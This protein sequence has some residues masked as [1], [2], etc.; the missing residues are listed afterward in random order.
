MIIMQLINGYKY[1]IEQDAQSAVALCN[2]YYGI[3]IEGDTTQ[4][5]C[6]YQV[7][8]L[9][10]PIFWYIIYDESLLPILG[11]PTEFEIT[12]EETI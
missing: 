8:E 1:T 10:T 7:A 4:N 5:W 6:M 12:Q 3:P 2:Q 9:N 11:N